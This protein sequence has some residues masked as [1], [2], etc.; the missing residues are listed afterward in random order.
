LKTFTE[1]FK[2]PRVGVS[3]DPIDEA[4]K[5]LDLQAYP[6]DYKKIKGIELA[7]QL[8][9][10]IDS[11]EN[12]HVED[13][14]ESTVGEPYKVF[15]SQIGEIVIAKTP[16]GEWHF[17]QETVN[18]IPLII[19]S[20]DEQNNTLG[21]ATLTHSDSI[22]S[23]IR[24]QMPTELKQ[25]LLSL[26]RW[27][28]LG[29]IALF[30]IA[31][32][33]GQLAK[34]IF[35]W[36]LGKILRKRFEFLTE[37]NIKTI[38]APVAL[39]AF[40]L[41]VRLGLRAIALTQNS[42]GFLRS[43]MFVLTAIAIIWL[44]YRIIDTIATRLQQRAIESKQQLDDLFIPFISAIVRIGIVVIGL[45]I[46]A[47]NLNFNVTGLIAGLGIGGIAIALASQ[48]TVSN[49]FGSLVLMIERPFM[50]EDRVSINGV[51]GTVREVGIR[52]T[53]ILTEDNS[54]VTMPNSTVAKS[55]IINQGVEH[56]RNWI[57]NLAVSQTNGMEKIK[58][59]SAGI[60]EIIKN[61]SSLNNEI[62]NVH[63]YDIT[64]PALI[65]RIEVNF[66]TDNF[67]FEL[68][69]R[70]E[71]ITEVLLLADKLKIQMEAAKK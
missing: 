19:G 50:P 67:D 58:S 32:I 39:L 49:F 9:E 27:Q 42:L 25:K 60:E 10:I 47:E 62:F 61:S 57:M 54:L 56:Y 3:P 33:I 30:I 51:D 16:S 29:L 2:Q 65:L 59:F 41:I 37:E 6:D 52:S 15:Q 55:N 35:S 11:V 5:C 7:S 45:I 66:K 1:A 18:S 71:F 17:T 22:G 63:I 4:V 69:A 31:V 20:I 36:L 13:A 70:Q 44:A 28:W 12:F 34:I 53:K 24:D 14:P 43:A 46:V 64:F 23:Q 21:S 38:S 26:E 68:K 48:E 8:L 40:V